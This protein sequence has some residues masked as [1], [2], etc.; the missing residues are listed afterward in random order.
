MRDESWGVPS[1]MSR[2][3]RQWLFLD[4]LSWSLLYVVQLLWHL[5]RHLLCSNGHMITRCFSSH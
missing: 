5:L 3:S 1:G 2:R 4:W